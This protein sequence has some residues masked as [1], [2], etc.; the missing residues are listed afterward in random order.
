MFSPG[1]ANINS[2]VTLV[3]VGVVHTYKIKPGCV[4]TERKLNKLE[5]GITTLTF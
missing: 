5:S 1:I 2:D 4:R 3:Y